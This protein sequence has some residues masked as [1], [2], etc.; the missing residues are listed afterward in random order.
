MSD[1]TELW[2]IYEATKVQLSEVSTEKLAVLGE[3][4]A[5]RNS[6]D[7]DAASVSLGGQAGSES[8]S[9]VSLQ[10]RF[11]SLVRA[12]RELTLILKE[13]RQLAIA[14]DPGYVTSPIMRRRRI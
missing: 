8:Y 6:G 3:I 7:A 4:T 2:D 14:A 12:E 1:I 9:L 10:A 13:Q 5:L 11:D